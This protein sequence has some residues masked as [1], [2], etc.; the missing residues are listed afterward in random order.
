MVVNTEWG[1]FGDNGEIEFVRNEF[2]RQLDQQSL[3][4]RHQ[5]YVV[6]HSTQYSV[7][8]TQYNCLSCLSVHTYHTLPLPVTVSACSCNASFFKRLH[9]RHSLA[10]WYWYCSKQELQC[11]MLQMYV[12]QY[13]QVRLVNCLCL[14]HKC[15]HTNIMYIMQLS[16]T[17]SQLC[18]QHL[19][20]VV[21]YLKRQVANSSRSFLFQ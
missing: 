9:T 8:R 10:Q 3:N 7:H 16:I 20:C 17:R 13:K 4:P 11:I 12:V 18:V 6:Y 14:C 21:V 5:L 1:A 15:K 2:D 19:C